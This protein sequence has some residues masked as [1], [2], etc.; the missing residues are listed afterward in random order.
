LKIFG[1]DMAGSYDNW[2]STPLGRYMDA[3]EKQLIIDLLAPKPGERILDVGCGTGNHLLL[4]QKRGCHVTGVEPSRAMMDV[5]RLKLDERAEIKFGFAEDL[6]FSDNEF[7]VVTMITSLEFTEDP[8]K[9][10]REAVRVSR[11]RVF[12]GVLNKYSFLGGCRNFQ[13]RFKTSIYNDA[14]FYSIGELLSLIGSILGPVK[15]RWGSV[16]FLPKTFYSFAAG[17]EEMIPVQKNPFGA[18]MGLVFSVVYQYRTLQDAIREPFKL[19]VDATREAQGAVRAI[20]SVAKKAGK[21]AHDGNRLH[22]TERG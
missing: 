13:G 14:R 22:V 6:P 11:D 21:R 10:L 3:R 20:Q 15:I 2:L 8:A 9:A 18:F 16:I 17:V 12:L 1:E 19:G 7:D 4:F 5:A